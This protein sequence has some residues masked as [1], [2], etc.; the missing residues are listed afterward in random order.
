MK[1]ILL[2]REVVEFTEDTILSIL[3]NHRKVSIEA[4]ALGN[5]EKVEILIDIDLL[6]KEANLT[7]RQLQIVELYFIK[8]LTQEQA[9]ETLGI[10][11]QAVCDQLPI[12]KRQIKAVAKK[13]GDR[14]E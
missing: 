11:Q 10:S 5:P 7:D 12:I 1:V 14:S 3:S 2:T 6:L 13:W 9:A 8:Q 4:Y